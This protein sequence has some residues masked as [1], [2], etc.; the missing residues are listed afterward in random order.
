M[1]KIRKYINNLKLKIKNIKTNSLKINI[2]LFLIAFSIFI[3]CFLWFFQIVFLDSYY[4]SY[5][6]EE[7]DK[8][9]TE[10]KESAALNNQIIEDIAERRDIC[11][12]IYGQNTYL[13]TISNKGCM[14]FGN[15]NFKVKQNFINSNRLE[16]HYTLINE[17][18]E[19][20]TLIYALK[21]DFMPLLMPL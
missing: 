2:W 14:E 5:K 18:F 15:R 13:S 3:L 11:I 7:L 21:L 8:A 6:T 1:N 19:N 12:E 17:K 4:K 10:L 16:Q 20:E 9:A